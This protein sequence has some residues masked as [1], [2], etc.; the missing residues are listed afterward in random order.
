MG[1]D[2]G[3]IASNRRYL[4]GAGS[5]SHTAD[6]LQKKKS[7][8]QEAEECHEIMR[9]C[10]LTGENLMFTVDEAH[11][12]ATTSNNSIVACP[13]GK[14]Y[15]KEAAIEALLRRKM[16]QDTSSSELG[17][18]IR[19][20]KDLY[21]V[22]FHLVKE[23][24]LSNN[25]TNIFTPACP[26]TAEPLNGSHAAY[27][28]VSKKKKKN[29]S[30]NSITTCDNNDVKPNVIS[31]RAIKQIGIESIQ[32]EYGTFD[33]DE[34]IRIAPPSR[35]LQKIKDKLTSLRTEQALKKKNIKK[36]KQKKV[37]SCINS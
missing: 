25:N 28:I 24:N 3:V 20:L 12:N 15:G 7:P 13:F 37:S 29:D 32:A 14:L 9:T 36:S 34:M 1:G 21:P 4:R 19:G 31:D 8:E 5:A 30:S 17:S 2:G 35:D 22:R 10:A 33:P 27:V 16:D 11:P 23:S 18:H 26:F 6:R